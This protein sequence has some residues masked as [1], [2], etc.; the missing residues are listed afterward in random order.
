MN[1]SKNGTCSEGHLAFYHGRLYQPAID[2]LL[3]AALSVAA[4]NLH[5]KP[6]ASHFALALASPRQPISLILV[7]FGLIFFSYN[8]GF[9]RPVT[10]T[11]D[12]AETT[13]SFPRVKYSHFTAGSSKAGKGRQRDKRFS[14]RPSRPASAYLHADDSLKET[15]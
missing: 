12:F 1:A 7:R 15:W 3:L 13:R 5:I 10:S 4:A 9:F 6:F 14:L 11:R 2:P 8:N